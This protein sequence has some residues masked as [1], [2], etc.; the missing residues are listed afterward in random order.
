MP[1]KELKKKIEEIL[2]TGAPIYHGKGGKGIWTTNKLLSLC[3]EY[4]LSYN[5]PKKR[6]FNKKQGR[7]HKAVF[8][9]INRGDLKRKPCEV[10]ES[11][12]VQ[13][14]HDDYDKPLDVRW[15]C[16]IHHMRE[17]RT[18]KMKYKGK[19]HTQLV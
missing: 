9:A 13:G 4:A 16:Q 8:D 18:K 15:L 12:Q 17:D 14:H 3:K 7:A 6:V 19:L 5:K 2:L 10:C 1:D 11:E